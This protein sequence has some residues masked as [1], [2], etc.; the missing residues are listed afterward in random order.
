[1]HGPHAPQLQQ[2][3]VGQNGHGARRGTPN[4]TQAE[5]LQSESDLVLALHEVRSRGVELDVLQHE[6]KQRPS[7]SAPHALR[8]SIS[9]SE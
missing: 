7:A 6:L 4:S 8:S 9:R 5:V 3:C 2:L 1:M